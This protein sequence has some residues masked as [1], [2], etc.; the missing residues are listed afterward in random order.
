MN[1]GETRRSET[2][3]SATWYASLRQTSGQHSN[4][5]NCCNEVFQPSESAQLDDKKG[6][7]EKWPQT[8]SSVSSLLVG[9]AGPIAPVKI[10][11][12][13]FVREITLLN[14]QPPNDF[15]LS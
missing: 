11:P 9:D 5:A 15:G 4:P 3:T 6:S 1:S 10:S 8:R 12:D 7:L 13:L 14:Q 2:G